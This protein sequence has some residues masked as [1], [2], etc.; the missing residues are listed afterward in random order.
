MTKPRLLAKL[1][2]Y[3]CAIPRLSVRLSTDLISVSAAREPYGASWVRAICIA[4]A[5]V[6]MDDVSGTIVVI[7]VRDGS[8]TGEG[9]SEILSLQENSKVA[10]DKVTRRLVF[11]IDWFFLIVNGQLQIY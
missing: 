4:L 3:I 6:T 10:V 11:M 7:G 2:I 9:G 5:S 8:S 1:T